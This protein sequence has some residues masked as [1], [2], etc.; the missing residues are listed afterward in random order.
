MSDTDSL[1]NHKIKKLK[2][3]SHVTKESCHF[4]KN[5]GNEKYTSEKNENS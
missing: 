5:S 1:D 2:Q 4:A 3:K